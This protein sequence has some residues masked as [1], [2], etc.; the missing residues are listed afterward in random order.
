MTEY[1]SVYLIL[2]SGLDPGVYSASN[3]NERKK[4]NNYVTGK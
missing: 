2:P 4:Q 3:K 1:V